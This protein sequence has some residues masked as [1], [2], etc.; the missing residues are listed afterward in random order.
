MSQD[1][2]W[3]NGVPYIFAEPTSEQ[4][5]L[6]RQSDLFKIGD[7]QLV[8]M[9]EGA[10]SELFL[11]K[12]E[13]DARIE[14]AKRAAL[15]EAA[16]ERDALLKDKALLSG[17]VLEYFPGYNNRERRI[18]RQ[19]RTLAK[20][21]ARRHVANGKLRAE[22]DALRE[23]LDDALQYVSRADYHHYLKPETRALLEG[24]GND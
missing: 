1:K 19:R 15:A 12:A 20:M 23:A 2:N 6:A 17:Q 22:R 13:V 14:W 10:L 4:R 5:A 8:W 3:P 18:A 24:K 7:M 9:N 21:Y 16:A 11:P